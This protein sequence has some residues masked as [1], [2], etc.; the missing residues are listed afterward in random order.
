M[1]ATGYLILL[2]FIVFILYLLLIWPCRRRVGEMMEYNRTMFAHR[3]YHNVEKYIPENSMAAFRAAV[4]RGY[5]IELDV[6]ITKDGK[7]AVFHDDTLERM[8]HAPGRVESYTFA[9]L[10]QFHLLNTTEKIPELEEVL[11]YVRG[12]VPLLIELKITGRDLEI[13]RASYEVL[14]N[15]KGRY[16]IQSFH[17]LGLYWYRK[18]APEVLRGQL[19]SDLTRTAQKDPY[20]LRLMVKYLLTNIIGRPDFISYKLKDLPNLSVSLCRKLFGIP[21]AVWTLRTEQALKQG[22]A[23]YNICIFEKTGKNYY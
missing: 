23:K 17:T 1:T 3:G 21:V 15:Y 6:H 11:S 16:L 9:E 7:L 8:C 5:G 13:C 12:R 2:V 4:E 14:K 18:N 10:Q 20:I 22:R 19:S